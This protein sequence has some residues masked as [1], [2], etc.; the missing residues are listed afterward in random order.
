M[1]PQSPYP[2]EFIPNLASF[3]SLSYNS[4]AL[5]LVNLRLTCL[6]HRNQT[7]TKQLL[8]HLIADSFIQSIA[9]GSFL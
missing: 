7:S 1:K 2:I 4:K 9:S 3:I 8:Y 5:H 6:S